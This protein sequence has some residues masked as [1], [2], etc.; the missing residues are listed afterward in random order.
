M[1]QFKKNLKAL[2]TNTL[3]L[4]GIKFPRTCL[5][6]DHVLLI[7]LVITKKFSKEAF[8]NIYF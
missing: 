3:K 4:V 6:Q 8:M 1:I 5:Q 2:S 7:P